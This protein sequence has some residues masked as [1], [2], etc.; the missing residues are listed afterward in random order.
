M[1]IYNN[2]LE[3]N[4]STYNT[5]P[6]DPRIVN[7]ITVDHANLCI[8][9]G[10]ASAFWLLCFILGM[11]YAV[12]YKLE[13]YIRLPIILI[14]IS[15]AILSLRNAI[16]W[17][18]CKKQKVQEGWKGRECADMHQRIRSKETHIRELITEYNNKMSEL[19]RN[20][21]QATQKNTELENNVSTA[22]ENL[23]NKYSQKITDDANQFQETVN[24]GN[25][26]NSQYSNIQ[27]Y[28]NRMTADL[29]QI[30]ENTQPLR[31]T[32]QQ[33]VYNP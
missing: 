31:F 33:N 14:S 27:T 19:N 26:W 21:T 10:V 12:I 9:F 17:H 8:Y 29:A 11:I 28:A 20:I 30:R 3:N 5:P 23:V 32:Q 24:R 2:D 13:L 16:L 1:V 7:H 15:F 22:I 6:V 4:S 25:S 18:K